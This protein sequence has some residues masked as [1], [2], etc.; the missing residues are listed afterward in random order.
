MKRRI[1]LLM[2]LFICAE[3]FVSCDSNSN[4]MLEPFALAL[5][6]KYPQYIY[7]VNG[8]S[9]VESEATEEGGLLSMS[10]YDGIVRGTYSAKFK[11]TGENK[12]HVTY[13]YHEEGANATVTEMKGGSTT[14][15]RECN[16]VK[17]GDNYYIQNDKSID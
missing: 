4:H 13:T 5:K 8:Y 11:N 12:W 3:S 16:L 15:Y 7:E 17:Q 9:I 10:G 6:A 14:L 2:A 1:L